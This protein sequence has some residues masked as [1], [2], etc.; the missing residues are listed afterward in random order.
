[1]CPN[2]AVSQ[3]GVAIPVVQQLAHHTLVGLNVGPQ[4]LTS[5]VHPIQPLRRTVDPEVMLLKKPPDCTP[6]QSVECVSIGTDC[7]IT[8]PVFW[9]ESVSNK[10]VLVSS[11]SNRQVL[12]SSCN[13]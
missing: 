9:F 7:L 3:E 8:N 2:L 13:H 4:D 1:M 12:V 11:V 6:A 5:A 10:Q